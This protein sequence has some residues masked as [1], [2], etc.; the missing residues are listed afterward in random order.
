MRGETSKREKGRRCAYRERESDVH[1]S[2]RKPVHTR[3]SRT[4]RGCRH[5]E[6]G[7]KDTHT[8]EKKRR[9]SKKS[10]K[11]TAVR[12]C[13]YNPADARAT[14][15]LPHD[16]YSRQAP[17]HT[18]VCS[19]TPLLLALFRLSCGTF[20]SLQL[21]PSLQPHSRRCF[22]HAIFFVCYLLRASFVAT[23]LIAVSALS[24]PLSF[25]FARAGLTCLQVRVCEDVRCSRKV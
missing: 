12:V 18:S 15:S 24:F 3:S 25:V 10:S 5:A 13:V 16:G 14:H 19:G 1:G 4:H 21:L 9:K 7:G 8:Q 23:V 11:G 6:G 20:P 17:A 2:V 22:A